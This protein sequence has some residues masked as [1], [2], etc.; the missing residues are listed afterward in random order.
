MSTPWR[1][2]S[3]R[4][5]RRRRRLGAA[6]ASPAG[7][8]DAAAG[9]TAAQRRP[10]RVI[11]LRDATKVFDTGAVS[12]RALRGVTLQIERGDFVAIMGSSGSGKTTLMNILGC[13][14]VP[15]SGTYLIDGVDVST[16]DEDDLSDLRNHKIG[17]VFQSF[18][19]VPR[20]AALANVELPLAYAGLHRDERRR[21]A[22]AALIAV[23][24]RDRAHHTP[25]ELSG[26]QQQRV[27]IARALVTNPTLILADEP[28]GN[29]DSRSGAEVIAIFERLHQQGRTVV[30]I[31]HEAEVAAHTR[32]IV[33]IA[34]GL[35]VSD[36]EQSPAPR[37][38]A[39][40]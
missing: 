33:R 32:R 35:I 4:V 38:E 11:D 1:P 25:A 31:T 30:L 12:V 2:G 3:A 39:V 24:M 36:E 5:V 23:G 14:D 21:R 20:T 17:F 29:L 28:T 18:N 22:A 9:G 13:L 10:R 34:D 26:G 6:P 15:S 7:A 27:A 16:M 37:A 19:L 8:R 40:L